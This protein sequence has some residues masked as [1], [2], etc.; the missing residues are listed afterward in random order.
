MCIC[1]A[2]NP[3]GFRY[4]KYVLIHTYDML[5]VSNESIKIM[6]YVAKVYELKKELKTKKTYYDAPR[7][8]DANVGKFNLPAG[9]D[10]D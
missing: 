9:S 4:L 5:V 2:M 8:L 1:K 7:Y 10:T 3:Y 6:G